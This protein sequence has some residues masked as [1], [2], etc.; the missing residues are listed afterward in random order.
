MNLS[1]NCGSSAIATSGVFQEI[2]K[3]TYRG[4]LVSELLEDL[5][6]A[7]ISREV[8]RREIIL[9]KQSKSYF[10]ISGAGHEVLGLALARSLR[11]AYDWF[12]PYYRD[13]ALVLGLGVSV[14]SMLLQSVGA[15][16]DPASGGR[17]MPSHWGDKSRNIVSQ[18]SPT[19]SQCIPAVGCAEATLYLEK[20]RIKGIAHYED[21]I[22]YVSLGEG[23]TSEGEFWES[24]NTVANLALPIL[25]VVADNGYAI[26]V[27]LSEQSPG[28]ISEMLASY[29]NLRVET[30]NGW[31]Y[32]EIRNK[33]K[34]IINEIRHGLGPA[35]V[36]AK[37]TRPFSHSSADDQSK[38][39]SQSELEE[40]ATLDPIA[41]FSGELID[42]KVLS[43]SEFDEIYTNCVNYV[44]KEADRAVKSTKPDPSTVTEHVY[45]HPLI[46]LG[47]DPAPSASSNQYNFADAIRITLSDLMAVD[48]RI[49]VFGQD[50]A[51]AP[52]HLLS[53]VP[54]KGGVFGLT[55]GLQST[56][57]SDRCFNT[58]LSEANIVGRAVGQAIRGLKPIAEIQFFDYIWTAMSQIKHEAA[59]LR[60]R[61]NGKFNCPLIIRVPIGGYLKGGAIWHSQSGES[62]FVHI[63][64]LIIMYPSGAYDAAAMLR[65]AYYC[66]D[67]VLFLE[68]KHLFRQR[69]SACYGELAKNPIGLGQ[70][71]IVKTGK[72]LTVVSWGACLH[73]SLN[74]I[75]RFE[76]ETNKSIELIDLR[77][78]SPWPKDLVRQSVSKTS[79]LLVV[80][81]DNLTMGF[82]SEISA[83]VA[84]HCFWDLDAPV[85]RVGALD[86]YVAYE[87]G[88][89]EAILPQ[90]NSIYQA[91]AELI[92]T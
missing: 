68:H 82:A 15:K 86:T 66:E 52:S 91:I 8:D 92:Q 1:A 72:D 4:Y 36:H 62:I 89:E 5:E 87:P 38:Y 45:V 34:K 17:Q 44:K 30:L 78:L 19:G 51:D 80:Q 77:F 12:F 3:L 43:Q 31:D 57:G 10:Q 33:T 37:V 48:E 14:Y 58:P 67:P 81:E 65:T 75:Q 73:K 9:Q 59:T 21:E 74:A 35:L 84:E 46:E 18:T 47:G 39:R 42:N 60:W 13:R 64:G 63:P 23:A 70:G 2:S 55:K 79:K 22:T 32:F 26:S 56:Y 25:F 24:L 50:V 76:K 69:Y 85:K 54:G 7:I 41:V 40:E 20:H 90:E 71:K 61:S 11:P 29:P 49:R 28:P 53:K 27:P 83:W 6:L 16:D 88:L